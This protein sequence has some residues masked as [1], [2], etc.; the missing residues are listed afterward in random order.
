V[1][2]AGSGVDGPNFGVT[3]MADRGDGARA[4]P[5]NLIVPDADLRPAAGLAAIRNPRPWNH[6]ER[7]R[8][9]AAGGT[10]QPPT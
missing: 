3:F 8:M 2:G 10:G 4:E 9:R 6:S 7:G 5:I 1:V